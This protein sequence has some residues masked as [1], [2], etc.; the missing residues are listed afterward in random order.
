M[1][2]AED[3]DDLVDYMI[4]MLLEDDSEMDELEEGV[5]PLLEDMGLEDEQATEVRTS[6][7]SSTS[8]S[9]SRSAVQMNVHISIRTCTQLLRDLPASSPNLEC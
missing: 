4:G 7:S 6:T 8:S 3:V 1:H 2:Y 9:T 5:V